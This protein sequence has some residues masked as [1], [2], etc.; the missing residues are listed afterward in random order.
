MPVEWIRTSE[1]F[2]RVEPSESDFT[3]FDKGDVI[4]RVQRVPTGP[5]EGLWMWTMTAVRPGPPFRPPRSGL[6]TSLVGATRRVAE[7]YDQLRFLARPGR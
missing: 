6:E 7:A 1:A 5:D 4:R 3:A 2:A